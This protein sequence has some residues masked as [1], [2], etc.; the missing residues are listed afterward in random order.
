M[1]SG[2]KTGRGGSKNYGRKIKKLK[3]FTL[4]SSQKFIQHFLMK[5]KYWIKHS[6]KIQ[7]KYIL[8][9]HMMKNEGNSILSPF[10]PYLNSYVSV[11][12]ESFVCGVESPVLNL[13]LVFQA[14]FTGT[15]WCGGV[16]CVQK[17]AVVKSHSANTGKLYRNTL[18]LLCAWL[19]GFSWVSLRNTLV[20]STIST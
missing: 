17:K 12:E 20:S 16:F 7:L 13:S 10:P 15:L 4:I 6:N 14:V 3:N 5:L 19:S 18:D 1:E 8:I 2:K 11:R 9:L